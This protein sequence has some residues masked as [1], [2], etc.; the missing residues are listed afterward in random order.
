V[1]DLTIEW[2]NEF[3][4]IAAVSD[5]P[6]D[7]G[8]QV[9]VEWT[10]SGHDFVGDS[11][12]IVEY[13][14][15]RQIDQNLSKTAT[16]V[17]TVSFDDL[18]AV[19]RE[20]ALLMQSAGWDFITTIPVS[21][22]DSYAVV[23][24]TLAD[25]TISGGSYLTTFIV[26]ALTATPGVFFQ[27]PPDSGYS[28]DNLAPTVPSNFAIAYNTGSGNSL[29][30]DEAQESDFQYYRVYRSND[31]NFIPDAGSLVQATTAPGWVDPDYDGGVVYYKVTSTD[32]AG[33]ESD[34]AV[35]DIVTASPQTPKVASYVLHQNVPNPFN[36]ATTIRYELG[37]A[38][39]RVKLQIFDVSG[40]LVNTLI[41]GEQQEGAHSVQ[42]NGLDNTGRRVATGAYFYRLIA[43]GFT[44]TKKMVML[45]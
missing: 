40:R 41:D 13:A 33:N 24:P 42:W 21:V 8:K 3:A 4:N 25:S 6:N 20:D 43:P 16:Q 10:R 30:W 11:Q 7:Q 1:N 26:R 37:G 36:P 9:R 17:A 22:E 38:G 2:L 31:P 35:A 34:P 32:F 29:S 12:Q 18:S 5:I 19:A 27:S 23:V 39:G 14:V 44:Q 28:V 45:K 15:Y